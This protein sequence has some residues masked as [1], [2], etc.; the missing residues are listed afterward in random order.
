MHTCTCIVYIYP[1]LLHIGY[2]SYSYMH[3]MHIYISACRCIHIPYI[4]YFRCFAYLG[5]LHVMHMY[6]YLHICTCIFPHMQVYMHYMYYL[7]TRLHVCML[8]ILCGCHI[9][10][11]GISGSRDFGVGSWIPEDPGP[12]YPI[13]GVMSKRTMYG[14]DLVGSH[15]RGT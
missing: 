15:Q 11:L 8:C 14:S 13:F 12:R 7:C 3:G 9:P 10:Y 2:F 5:Y 6:M 4:L 1:L